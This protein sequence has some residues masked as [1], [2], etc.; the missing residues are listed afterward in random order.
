[1]NDQRETKLEADNVDLLR[2]SPFISKLENFWYHNKWKVIIIAFFAIVLIVGVAQVAGKT[3]PDATVVVAVPETITPLQSAD[4]SSALVSV[5]P[6]DTNGD[7]KKVIDVLAYPI[8]SEEEFEEANHT[9]TETE[10]DGG[11][12]YVPVVNQ[13]YNVEKFN[14]YT[15]FLKT[16]EATVL[17]V[18][19]YLYGNLVQND[20]VMPLSEIFGENVPAGAKA[21]GFGFVFGDLSIYSYVDALGVIPEDSVV[22][23]LRPYIWGASSDPERYAHAKELF[24]KIVTF[25]E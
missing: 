20:R 25:G 3:E 22:C 6:A 14:E 24:N 17:I 7:G 1:M 13:S 19:E 15:E 2:K 4:I 18:S 5:M 9:E 11:W 16:G 8:Y 12:H 23:I 21:D 10:K